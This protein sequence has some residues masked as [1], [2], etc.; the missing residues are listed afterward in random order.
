[1]ASGSLERA[2][3]LVLAKVNHIDGT[4]RLELINQLI[5][6]EQVSLRDLGRLASAGIP[7][8]KG[9]RARCWQLLLGYLPPRRDSWQETLV[10][11]REEYASFCKDFALSTEKA[12]QARD[13]D[14][15]ND[16]EDSAWNTYFRDVEEF[17]Q[18][19][20]DVERTHQG[21]DFF[22]CS[23][24]SAAKHREELQRLLFVFSKLN[25]G[26]RYVQ[27]M[28]EL[29]APLYYVFS[30]DAAEQSDAD[31][32]EADTFFAFVRLLTLS[33]NRDLYCKSLDTAAS[34]VSA[35]MHEFMD[36]LAKADPKVCAHLREQGINPHFFAFRWMTVLFAQDIE[37]LSDV[38]RVWDSL[39]GDSAGCKDATMRVCCAL[40]LRRRT[41]LL[42]VEFPEIIKV[43]QSCARDDFNVE[44]TLNIAA[45]LSSQYMVQQQ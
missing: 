34:G 2:E 9:V 8:G 32:A 30:T 26:L 38:L 22:A 1:M 5:Q 16:S 43:L 13:D 24:P 42:A 21:M 17:D 23:T 37:A 15:L 14:P 25:P 31:A 7:A 6:A 40:V 19:Q 18:I 12:G 4:E 10:K 3:H 11:R 45:S 41:Q 27:G 36:E 39:F 29:A 20:R 44:D 28:N 35:V 33:E